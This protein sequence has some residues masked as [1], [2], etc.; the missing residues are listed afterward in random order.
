MTKITIAVNLNRLDD[1]G[2]KA[3]TEEPKKFTIL[4]FLCI[5]TKVG[6]NPSSFLFDN[7]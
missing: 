2:L 1:I 7:T 3:L 4:F 5:L 6:F